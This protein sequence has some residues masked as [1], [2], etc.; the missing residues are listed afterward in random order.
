MFLETWAYTFTPMKMGDT[1]ESTYI[2]S[3]TSF[4]G[5]KRAFGFVV[6]PFRILIQHVQIS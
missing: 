5:K 4:E 2:F 1:Q 6:V 3:V